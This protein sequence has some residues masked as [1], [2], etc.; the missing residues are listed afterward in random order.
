MNS[1]RWLGIAAAALVS[2]ALLIGC[3]R[4]AEQKVVDAKANVVDAQR[5][6]ADAVMLARDE[7]Q[8]A[9]ARAEWLLFKN[10]AEAR[11]VGN[12]RII[13]AY[14][15]RMTGTNGK[16]RAMYDKKID[17][18]ELKNKELKAK[19]NSYHENGKNGWEQFKSEFGRDMTEL[20]SAL[21]DFA[22]DNKK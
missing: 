21:K 10:D 15:A 1:H 5:E 16:L 11:I 22:V 7:A 9:A 3:S 6:A 12:D 13:V 2:L 19:L 20:G 4:S 18:L 14:K 17:A 8:Q